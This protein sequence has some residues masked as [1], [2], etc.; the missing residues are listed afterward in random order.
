[1]RPFLRFVV[2]RVWRALGRR[3]RF[4]SRLMLLLGAAR[5]LRDRPLSRVRVRVNPGETLV[6]G[7]ED[8][9]RRG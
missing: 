9:A 2:R 1:M 8:G 5:F 6:V 4:V 7:F 3:Y